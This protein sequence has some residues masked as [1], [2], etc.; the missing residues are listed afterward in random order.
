MNPFFERYQQKKTQIQ[1]NI[2]PFSSPEAFQ[3]ASGQMMENLN[4]M[5]ITPEA[6]VKQM[7]QSGQMSQQ[8]FS[9]LSQQADQIYS[10]LFGRRHG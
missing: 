9:Q 3:Q 4:K 5:G 1:Q 6:R 10:M 2:N 8:Q 7:M